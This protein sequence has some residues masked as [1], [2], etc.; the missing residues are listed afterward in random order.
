MRVAFCSVSSINDTS[1]WSGTPY[2]MAQN[3]RKLADDF[4]SIGPLQLPTQPFKQKS[5]LY[6]QIFREKYLWEL[7]PVL[8][9]CLSEEVNRHLRALGPVDVIISPGCFPYPNLF[10]RSSVPVVSWADATFNG[11][12]EVHPGFSDACLENRWCGNELQQMMFDKSALSIFSSKW[13]TDSAIANYQVSQNALRT[14]P[15]GANLHLTVESE[16]HLET[17]LKQRSAEECSLVIVAKQWYEKGCGFALAVQEEVKRAGLPCSLTMVGCKVP[18]E[19]EGTLGA[20]IIIT[21]PIFKDGAASERAYVEVL[22]KSHFLL[23][24]S[25]GD[26]FGIAM[27]EA[28]AW[29]LPVLAHDTGGAGSIIENG[30]NGFTFATSATPTDYAQKIVSIFTTKDQYLNLSR[31]SWYQFASRLNWSKAAQEVYESV[32]NIIARS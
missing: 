12:V 14:V 16:L 15:F 5:T 3:L 2:F 26:C 13:A 28:N 6:S 22:A 24:P 8:H 11:L 17:V 31:S 29:G 23:H 30:I 25:K 32:Q 4:V 20:D 18:P 1:Y 9:Q 19:L 27:C 21:P 10:L 7:E